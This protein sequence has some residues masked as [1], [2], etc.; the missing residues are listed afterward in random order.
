MVVNKLTNINIEIFDKF[1]KG[2]RREHYISIFKPEIIEAY[3]I[4]IKYNNN[5]Y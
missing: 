4:I 3:V 2:N 5:I 1:W